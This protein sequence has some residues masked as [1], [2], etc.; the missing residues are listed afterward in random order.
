MFWLVAIGEIIQFF[1]SKEVKF[2]YS[3]LPFLIVGLSIMQLYKYIYI[4]RKRYELIIS[5][6]HPSFNIS[7]NTGTTIVIFFA[8]FSTLLP[9]VLFMIFN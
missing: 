5:A 1:M 9:F 7:I 4:T 3:L 8:F 6:E 2:D